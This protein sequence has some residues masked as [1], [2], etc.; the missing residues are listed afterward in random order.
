[1]EGGREGG[2][3]GG[4]EEGRDKMEGIN[5]VRSTCKALSSS[6]HLSWLILTDD[7][8]RFLFLSELALSCMEAEETRQNHDN[9]DWKKRM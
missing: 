8:G 3:E 9:G 6:T 4:S 2:K 7:F 5:N 1:M